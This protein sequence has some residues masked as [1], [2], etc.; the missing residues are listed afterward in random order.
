MY[1][2]L[3]KNNTKN[4]VNM[5]NVF[6]DKDKIFQIY[7]INIK[8]FKSLE[9]KKIVYVSSYEIRN[10]EYSEK[11]WDE[12]KFKCLE[13]FN[14]FDQRDFW[15]EKKQKN[16]D[17][18]TKF[19]IYRDLKNFQRKQLIQ[20]ILK[21]YPD[22]FE[23]YGTNWDFKGNSKISEINHEKAKRLYNGN[24]CLDL[25][26]KCGSLTLYPRSIDIIE[27]GGLLLQLKQTDGENIFGKYLDE[28]TFNNFEKLNFK[29]E[30]ISKDKE[31]FNELMLKQL[32]LFKDSKEKIEN[33]MDNLFKKD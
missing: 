13:K 5:K 30:K 28:F 1:I 18:H 8:K 27:N 26:S 31:Y 25:G 32:E 9:N 15:N 20:E 7:P 17:D 22:Q 33:Q 29:I 6:H 4:F 10:A 23:L 21:T 16:L 2:K 19:L 11:I 3:Q 12:I 24:I 14:Y